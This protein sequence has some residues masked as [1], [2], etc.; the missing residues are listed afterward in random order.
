M[1]Q[2]KKKLMILTL[3]LCNVIIKLFQVQTV[4]YKQNKIYVKL[5]QS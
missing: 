4:Y 5:Q 3:I 2:E 1:L